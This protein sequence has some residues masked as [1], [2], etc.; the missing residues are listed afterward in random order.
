MLFSLISVRWFYC[1][2]SQIP[3]PEQLIVHLYCEM[4]TNLGQFN[5]E[6]F[7]IA[8]LKSSFVAFC[9]FSVKSI[10][11]RTILPLCINVLQGL[12]H[13]FLL[14]RLSDFALPT[15]T[16]S[17]YTWQAAANSEFFSAHEQLELFP[18]IIL[19]LSSLNFICH[20][21]AQS[22]SFSKSFW[23]SSQSSKLSCL[24]SPPHDSVIF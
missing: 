20:H 3:L 13:Y 7:L 11:Q 23:T 15:I 21:I 17:S 16:P 12:P 18:C 5:Q 1:W 22:F 10:I 14:H 9:M 24:V 19:Y 8:E 2:K 4:G 6:Q